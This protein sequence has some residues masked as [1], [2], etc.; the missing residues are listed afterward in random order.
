MATYEPSHL[1]PT[2][3]ATDAQ[4]GI[5]KSTQQKSGSKH[6]M[7]LRD[8]LHISQTQSIFSLEDFPASLF[9]KPDEERVRKTIATYGQKCF[10]SYESFIRSS[11]TASEGS[12]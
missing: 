6:S 5:R 7:G 2:P 3:T 1:I 12:I 10:E 8:V 11:F 4:E 9:P